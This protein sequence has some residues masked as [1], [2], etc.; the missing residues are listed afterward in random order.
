MVRKRENDIAERKREC[1]GEV[2]RNREK[3]RVH[4]AKVRR[5]CEEERVKGG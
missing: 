1:E 2:R 4:W 5:K 3:K